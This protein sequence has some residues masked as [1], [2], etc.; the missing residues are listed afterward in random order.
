MVQ[1]KDHDFWKSLLFLSE[2]KP[3]FLSPVFYFLLLPSTLYYFFKKIFM[4]SV[5]VSILF[6]G[7]D[8]FLPISL[9]PIAPNML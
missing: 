4:K 7:K 5:L 2:R 6:E 9:S 8:Y 3:F 1:S